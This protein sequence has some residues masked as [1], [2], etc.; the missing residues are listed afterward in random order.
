FTSSTAAGPGTPRLS[1]HHGDARLTRYPS[2]LPVAPRVEQ[3]Q[4]DAVLHAQSDS[5]QKSLQFRTPCGAHLLAW[6]DNRRGLPQR[7]RLVVPVPLLG[8]EQVVYVPRDGCAGEQDRP[9]LDWAELMEVSAEEHD[10]DTS[11]IL[12]RFAQPA[13]LLVHGV[14]RSLTNVAMIKSRSE[15]SGLLSEQLDECL[16]NPCD[17]ELT[18]CRTKSFPAAKND[19]WAKLDVHSRVGVACGPIGVGRRHFYIVLP[20]PA[21]TLCNGRLARPRV[22]S[23]CFGTFSLP[24][25]RGTHMLRLD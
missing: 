21:I 16:D 10:G 22:C 17:L 23:V 18:F 24:L 19:L 20:K 13:E 4:I 14:Q 1:P 6:H 25:L 3:V 12:L 2:I 5:L 11:E 9:V 8:L 15:R 7:V